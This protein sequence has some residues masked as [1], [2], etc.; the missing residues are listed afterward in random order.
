M[1]AEVELL[2]GRRLARVDCLQALFFSA[3]ATANTNDKSSQANFTTK[4][5]NERATIIPLRTVC[6][7]YSQQIHLLN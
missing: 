3:I 6:L 1:T 2:L 5:H 4:N 7:R